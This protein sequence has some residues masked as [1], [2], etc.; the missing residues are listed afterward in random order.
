MMQIKNYDGPSRFDTMGRATTYSEIA[1]SMISNELPRLG[2]LVRQ[3]ESKEQQNMVKL[4]EC[5]LLGAILTAPQQAKLAFEIPEMADAIRERA[6]SPAS[7]AGLHETDLVLP[8]GFDLTA[9]LRRAVNNLTPTEPAS[10]SNKPRWTAHLRHMLNRTKP[11]PAQKNIDP[12]LDSDPSLVVLTAMFRGAGNR[13][14]C[15]LASDVLSKALEDIDILEVYGLF[16]GAT[17]MTNLSLLAQTSGN[18]QRAQNWT[19]RMLETFTRQAGF[20]HSLAVGATVRLSR[21]ISSE[22]QLS[23][24]ALVQLNSLHEYMNEPTNILQIGLLDARYKELWT[25]LRIKT[26]AIIEG[27]PSSYW[28]NQPLS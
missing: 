20:A 13:A 7:A 12:L 6:S 18:A 25:D 16:T 8:E 2:D 4:L 9:A 28:K 17:I 3:L 10:E 5:G 14:D 22:V 26:A 21:S 11:T 23:D 19:L 27:I 15:N 1:S 24:Q